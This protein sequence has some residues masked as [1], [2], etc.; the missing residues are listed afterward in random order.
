MILVSLIISIAIALSM[1]AFSVALSF[2]IYEKKYKNYLKLSLLVGVLHFIMPLLGSLT[3]YVALKRFVINGNKLMGVI[4]FILSIDMLYNYLKKEDFIFSSN[5]LFLLSLSVSIDS[6]FTGIGI[7]GI[8]KN[9][10]VSFMIFSF[11][12]FC[13]TLLGCYIGLLGKKYFGK[14]S[15]LL[16][17]II[18]FLLSVKFLLF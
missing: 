7:Y 8:T 12:S 5:K 18:L 9:P 4:I 3:N 10:F 1:D 16:A 6:Y 15:N 13:F 2:G 17:L 11:T 14:I